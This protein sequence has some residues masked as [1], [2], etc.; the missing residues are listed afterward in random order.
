M[1]LIGDGPP[2]SEGIAGALPARERNL[3]TAP[4]G[5]EKGDMSDA[6]SACLARLREMEAALARMER[7]LP[8][9]VRGVGAE[10]RRR[11]AEF[12]EQLAAGEGDLAQLAAALREI[13][14]MMDVL[15]ARLLLAPWDPRPAPGPK[16]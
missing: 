7:E 4:G 11:V 12:C 3:V 10:A 13:S 5:C 14:G 9:D 16:S 1:S 15:T 2:R 8:D 6:R